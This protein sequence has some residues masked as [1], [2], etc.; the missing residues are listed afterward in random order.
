MDP[1]TLERLTLDLAHEH[2]PADPV[3]LGPY[4]DA[5]CEAMLNLGI[6]RLRFTYDSDWSDI[7][8]LDPAAQS[9]GDP[10]PGELVRLLRAILYARLPP[11][12][13]MGRGCSGTVV[14][15]PQVAPRARF[16]H[17]NRNAWESILTNRAFEYDPD[18]AAL[19]GAPHAPSVEHFSISC[20]SD[21]VPRVED[22]TDGTMPVPLDAPRPWLDRLEGWFLGRLRSVAGDARLV[23]GEVAISRPRAAAIVSF[24][25]IPVDREETWLSID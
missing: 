7:V 3:E 14:V 24:N 18:L 12:I 13:S 10:P 1:E 17:V 6:D 9:T 11:D 21:R 19:I 25:F 16:D 4:L 5:A 20:G 8:R 15:D 22:T 2:D 23:R